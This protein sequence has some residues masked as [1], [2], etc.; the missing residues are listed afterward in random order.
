[1]DDV[2]TKGRGPAGSA[3]PRGAEQASVL[4][5]ALCTMLQTGAATY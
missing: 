3:P 2:E 4:E 5:D 1:M